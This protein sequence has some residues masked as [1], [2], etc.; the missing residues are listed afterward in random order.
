EKLKSFPD[1]IA[2]DLR[3]VQAQLRRHEALEHELS[4]AEQQ[5]QALV[6]AADEV[7][8]QCT[9][10]Q[11]AALQEKQQAVVENWEMLRAKVDQRREDLEQAC[12]IQRFLAQA[13]D[14]FSWSAELL[15]EMKVEEA[16]RDSFM[17]DLK[18]TQH[19]QLRAEIDARE[20]TFEQVMALGQEILHE[21][22]PSQD[23]R[24]KVTSLQDE[25]SGLYRQWELKRSWLERMLLQQI[26]YRDISQ[27][28]KLMNSQEVSVVG[29]VAQ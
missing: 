6:D 12:K 23:V 8:H 19:Q 27:M 11:S 7:L 28:E 15:R 21:S 3:G 16:T 13:R 2:K 14:Y 17:T 22:Y 18:L 29:D 24:D 10:Q 20:E 1:E 25:K 5:L 26:F 9:T 4:G